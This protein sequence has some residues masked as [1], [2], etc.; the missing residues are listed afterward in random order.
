MIPIVRAR[1][2]S[3]SPITTNT[4]QLPTVTLQHPGYADDNILFT[5]PA[6]DGDST[7]PGLHHRTLLTA[8]AIIADNAF[9]RAYITYDRAGRE[10]VDTTIPLDGLLQ[11][12]TYWLQLTGYEPFLLTI[13]QGAEAQDGQAEAEEDRQEYAGDDR[14]RHT[15]PIPTSMCP[16]PK[17]TT[18]TSKKHS[19]PITYPVVPSFRDWQFPHD[20]L[21]REWTQP[22]IDPSTSSAS[23]TFDRCA[24][25]GY[26]MGTNDCHI[27]PNN[28]D[29]WWASN[30]MR[31]YT[32]HVIGLP[33]DEANLM[34]LRADVHMLFDSHRFTLVPKPSFPSSLPSLPTQ[35]SPTQSP[36]FAFAVHVLHN[37]D[38]ALE[39]CDLYHNVAISQSSADRSRPQFLFARFAW[40]L[41]SHLQTFLKSPASRYLKVI[42]PDETGNNNTELKKMNGDE[43]DRHLAHRGVT[44]SGSKTRKRSRTIHDGSEADAD[45]A[46]QERWERRSRSLGSDDSDDSVGGAWDTSMAIGPRQEQ[47]DWNTRWYNENI[48]PKLLYAEEVRGQDAWDTP[49]AISSRQEQIAWN[50]RW[51]KENI[52]SKLSDAED[53]RSDTDTFDQSD[54]EE[55]GRGRQQHDHVE[56][57]S[58]PPVLSR[59]FTTHGSN[60]SSIFAD[61]SGEESDLGTDQLSV[62]IPGNKVLGAAAGVGLDQDELDTNTLPP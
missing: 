62:A 18:S 51:Y 35:S 59:S 49:M 43:L 40:A 61:F 11:P 55:C 4:K 37:D 25:T 20:R 6:V 10:R 30:R 29:I 5:L 44:R 36:S 3:L 19:N 31:Q 33:K 47:I 24:I 60:R 17:P 57:G 53:G 2:S 8:G 15:R 13:N 21:P 46:Y 1:L 16:P 45:D 32:R 41:F 54:G 48:A 27:V 34:K 12:G 58:S 38:E 9:D 50:T 28:Q 52:A 39:F 22:H 56:L 26:L 7:S 42:I 23:R 14:Q